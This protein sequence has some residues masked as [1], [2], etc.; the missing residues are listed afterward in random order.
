MFPAGANVV[1]VEAKPVRAK[2]AAV[3]PTTGLAVVLATVVTAVTVT[4][5]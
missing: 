4:T 3:G 2:A 5:G 1:V